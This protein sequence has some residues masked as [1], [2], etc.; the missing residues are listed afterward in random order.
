MRTLL[1]LPSGKLLVQEG[2]LAASSSFER[3]L[4]LEMPLPGLAE[5]SRYGV[6]ARGDVSKSQCAVDLCEVKRRSNAK[7]PWCIEHC[8]DQLEGLPCRYGT[9]H[10]YYAG[11]SAPTAA[12]GALTEE[13]IAAATS[14]AAGGPSAR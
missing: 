14:A 8:P 1:L 5:L 6:T 10:S 4:N 11:Q 7:C 13:A 3:E 2:G 9:T 12:A